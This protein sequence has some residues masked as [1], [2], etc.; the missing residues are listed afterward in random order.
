[1]VDF[2]LEADT[3]LVTIEDPDPTVSV[4]WDKAVQQAVINTN[5]EPTV[6]SRAYS[7]MH[8]A[9]FDAWAAYDPMAIADLQL[10]NLHRF[11]KR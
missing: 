7:L 2:Y 8:T 9:V 1:M 4:L 3:Q 6:A 5:P 11:L 10:L